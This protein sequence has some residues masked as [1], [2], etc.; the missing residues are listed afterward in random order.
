VVI[1]AVL[2]TRLRNREARPMGFAL[3]RTNSKVAA[4]GDW[5]NPLNSRPPRDVAFDNPIYDRLDNLDV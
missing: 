2:I 1:I 5:D 4:L 3:G